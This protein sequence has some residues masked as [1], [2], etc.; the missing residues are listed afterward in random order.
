MSKLYEPVL[1]RDGD[2][3]FSLHLPHPLFGMYMECIV[4]IERGEWV[5]VNC[6]ARR[7]AHSRLQQWWLEEGLP[8]V[9]VDEFD[10][11]LE[12]VVEYVLPAWRACTREG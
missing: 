2:E 1:V 5:E 10:R 8:D 11:A 3:L 7:D 6:L 9:L 4:S 12:R